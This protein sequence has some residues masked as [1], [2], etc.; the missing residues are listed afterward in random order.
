MTERLEY[1]VGCIQVTNFSIEIIHFN[2]LLSYI[3]RNKSKL[4]YFEVQSLV[5]I[6]GPKRLRRDRQH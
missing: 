4:L 5:E 6:E 1:I 3:I 2:D